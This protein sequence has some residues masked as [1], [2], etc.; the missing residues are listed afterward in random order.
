M[1]FDV[2]DLLIMEHD[3]PNMQAAVGDS[4]AETGRYLILAKYYNGLAAALAGSIPSKVSK[5]LENTV[6]PSFIGYGTLVRHPLAIM[7]WGFGPDQWTPRYLCAKLFEYE[8]DS[9]VIRN[10]HEKMPIT[11]M[12][13]AARYP[14]L[15]GFAFCLVQELVLKFKPSGDSL[16]W[17][18]VVVY[19]NYAPKILSKE[20]FINS[21]EVYY[22]PETDLGAWT[23]NSLYKK[24]SDEVWAR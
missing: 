8:D 11:L 12:T 23:F 22:K 6:Y 16:N 21:V 20:Q 1:K 4:C 3:L 2:Y 18:M 7:E 13:L 19:T 15:F 17:F 14:K 24:A 9:Y 10:M 5:Y